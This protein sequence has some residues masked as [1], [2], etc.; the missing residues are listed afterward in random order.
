MNNLQ[1]KLSP[2]NIAENTERIKKYWETEV[3]PDIHS[4]EIL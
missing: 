4:K 1:I 3:E 2:E